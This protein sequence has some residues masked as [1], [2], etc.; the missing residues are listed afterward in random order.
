MDEVHGAGIVVF[1]DKESGPEFLVLKAKWGYHWSIPKGHT[2]KQDRML[3]KTA[4]RETEEESGIAED[5][6]QIIDGFEKTIEYTLRKRTRRC[7]DGVKRVRVYLGRVEKD[8]AVNLSP[9]HTDFKWLP[10]LAVTR[11]LKSEFRDIM[12]EADSVCRRC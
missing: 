12:I 1:R 9:E 10:L 5:Q 6:I 4:L 8:I 7:P 2:D 3:L 11:F